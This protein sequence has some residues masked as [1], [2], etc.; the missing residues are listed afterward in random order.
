[1]I[2]LLKSSHPASKVFFCLPLDYEEKRKLCLN[3][4]KP[5][6]APQPKLLD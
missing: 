1:M 6:K 3:S 5:L 2:Y 4:V